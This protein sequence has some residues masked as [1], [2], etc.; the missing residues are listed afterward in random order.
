MFSHVKGEKMKHFERFFVAVRV[1]QTLFIANHKWKREIGVFLFTFSF[2]ENLIK[3]RQ[4][5]EWH[6]E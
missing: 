1:R 2:G 4:F 3:S 5:F 6:A